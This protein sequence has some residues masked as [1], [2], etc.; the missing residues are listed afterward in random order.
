MFLFV[1]KR[2]LEK[3]VLKKKTHVAEA[4]LAVLT[5]K[6][7]NLKTN[8]SKK[9]KKTLATKK[10]TQQSAKQPKTKHDQKRSQPIKAVKRGIKVTKPVEP[11][12][13]HKTFTELM[14]SD[15]ETDESD[16]DIDEH[17]RVIEH[18]SD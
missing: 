12:K 5:N 9:Q 4:A 15:S 18:D 14:A 1:L 11:R 16:I 10:T 13:K 3:R 7:S 6:N 17:G 2:A 8:K